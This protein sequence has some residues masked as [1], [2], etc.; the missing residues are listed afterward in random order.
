MDYKLLYHTLFNACTDALEDIAA[1]NFGLARARLIAAQQQT[2]DL[3]MTQGEVF[4]I[5]GEDTLP[6]AADI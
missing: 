2:E 5:P 6:Q 3:Y 1:Q 4:H